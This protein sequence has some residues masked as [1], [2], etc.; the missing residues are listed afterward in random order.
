M[1]SYTVYVENGEHHYTDLSDATAFA[2]SVPF[3][4]VFDNNYDDTD[5]RGVVATYQY[6]R[7]TEDTN[8]G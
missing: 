8:W 3:S 2:K 4:T 6:G 7:N 1:N 5:E